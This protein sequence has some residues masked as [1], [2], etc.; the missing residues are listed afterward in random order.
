MRGWVAT[1]SYVNCDV[2]GA[3][4]KY[5][6]MPTMSCMW[7]ESSVEKLLLCENPMKELNC[8]TARDSSAA[9]LISANRTVVG[10]VLLNEV[11]IRR[12]QKL[13]QN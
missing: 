8:E 10:I 11:Q 9:S 4:S 2:K 6:T 5:Q 13:D 7:A 12:T 1:R 3:D